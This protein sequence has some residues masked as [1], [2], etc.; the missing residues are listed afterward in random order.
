MALSTS[1]KNCTSVQYSENDAWFCACMKPCIFAAH[2]PATFLKGKAS[3]RDFRS[4]T[5]SL[6]II[7]PTRESSNMPPLHHY[8]TDG[9]S[10]LQTSKPNSTCWPY[11][12]DHTL[13]PSWSKACHPTRSG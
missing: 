10:R 12:H 3:G 2:T 5:S 4:C 11:C 1:C 7:P 8:I 6:R 13:P 9:V